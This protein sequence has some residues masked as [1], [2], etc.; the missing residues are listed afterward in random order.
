MSY[1][2]SNTTLPHHFQTPNWGRESSGFLNRCRWRLFSPPPPCVIHDLSLDR[3][4]LRWSFRSMCFAGLELMGFRRQF[5]SFLL[6][7]VG[8]DF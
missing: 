1:R 6:S 2:E 7:L 4:D 5:P 8:A 3:L